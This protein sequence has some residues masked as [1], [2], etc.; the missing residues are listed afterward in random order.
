M[1]SNSNHGPVNLANIMKLCLVMQ[2]QDKG[3][4]QIQFSGAK[5]LHER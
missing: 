1:M 4:I 5:R 2:P 3:L